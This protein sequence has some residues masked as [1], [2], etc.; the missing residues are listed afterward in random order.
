MPSVISVEFI[1][2]SEY[3]QSETLIGRISGA[4]V[5][6]ILNENIQFYR[7]HV[8][9]PMKSD[10]SKFNDDYY[11]Y[12]QLP[13]TKGNYSIVISNATYK[14][15]VEVIKDLIIANFTISNATADF[16]VNPGFIITQ[17]SFTIEIQNLKPTAIIVESKTN[18]ETRSNTIKGGDIKKINFEVKEFTEPTL[19]KLEISS[20]ETTYEIPISIFMN[21][22]NS[23][24]GDSFK[25]EPKEINFTM[26]TKSN[27]TRV[28]YISN[29]RNY[30]I[31]KI[32]ISV[33]G[34]LNDSLNLSAKKIFDIEGKATER[35][36]LFFSSGKSS[37]TIKGKLKF[38]SNDT[39]FFV[40]VSVSFLKDFIPQNI[41][42]PTITARS[43]QEL[44]GTF[45]NST[46]EECEEN[47]IVYATDGVCCTSSCK[48]I[49]TSSFSW[50]YTGWALIILVIIFVVWFWLKK[51]KK[52]TPAQASPGF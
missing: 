16:S 44:Y 14:N 5:K 26:A 27:Q 46:I 28:I 13:N 25:V 50:K 19:E 51:Y 20:D 17:N 15:G 2:K 40:P 18:S 22:T 11:I 42:E 34:D 49:K 47:K 9:V 48:E 31:T 7:G 43:C 1:I 30:L 36:E 29:L 37:T 21:K 12:A 38:E 24:V 8:K 32:E 33:F 6:P 3:K 41:S 23:N 45:C 10:V 4:F 39:S 35:M 52:V